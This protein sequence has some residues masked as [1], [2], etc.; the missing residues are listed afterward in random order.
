MCIRGSDAGTGGSSAVGPLAS[1]YLVDQLTLFQQ[2]GTD[3]AIPLTTVTS[4]NFHLPASLGGNTVI[5]MLNKYRTRA[6]ISHS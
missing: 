6:I 1:Q 3:S 5:T 4:K 2:W